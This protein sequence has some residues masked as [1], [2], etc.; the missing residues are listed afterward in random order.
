MSGSGRRP[1][2]PPPRRDTGSDVSLLPYYH[3]QLKGMDQVCT[4]HHS[5]SLI[6]RS[7]VYNAKGN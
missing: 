1:D 3:P 4:I 6:L 7:V 2:L 5:Q